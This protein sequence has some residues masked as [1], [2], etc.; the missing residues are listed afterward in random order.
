[1]RT[2][3]VEVA[4][5][6]DAEAVSRRHWGDQFLGRIV[7]WMDKRQFPNDGGVES[8][9][10]RLTDDT[11]RSWCRQSTSPTQS[12][13]VACRCLTLM[14]SSTT[15]H[16][17]DIKAWRC[18]WCTWQKTGRNCTT[19]HTNWHVMSR[20]LRIAVSWHSNECVSSCWVLDDA[21][22]HSFDREHQRLCEATVT[23]IGQNAF[24]RV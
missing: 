22:G 2:C 9:E 21:H 5:R 3:P 7:R 1:M 6:F 23:Q 19:Q 20:S 17:V 4:R 10:T 13:L 11:H 18:A 8:I 15:R 24:G 14:W 12:K 16:V